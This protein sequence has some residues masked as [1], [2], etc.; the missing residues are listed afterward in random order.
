MKH[1]LLLPIVLSLAACA[2]KSLY[3]WGGYEDM[4]YRGYKE[5]E[6]M[7]VMRTNLEAH[8]QKLQQSGEKVPPGLSSE[9]ATLFLQAGD[10]AK[11]RFYY[12]VEK[13]TWPESRKLMDALITNLDR[14]SKGNL[15]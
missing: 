6:K 13:T 4:L 10:K 7:S 5:P 3:Q 11:A 8:I 9:L 12:N 15:Q 2:P 1:L 14:T